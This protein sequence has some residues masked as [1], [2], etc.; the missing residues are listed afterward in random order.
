MFL[1][2]SVVVL[3]ACIILLLSSIVKAHR[4]LFQNFWKVFYLSRCLY[5]QGKQ[6]Q[7]C[8]DDD[9]DSHVCFFR[10]L[11]LFVCPHY[12]IVI[13]NC[14]CLS[15]VILELYQSN[16]IASYQHMLMHYPLH[17]NISLCITYQQTLMHCKYYISTY[18][19]TLCISIH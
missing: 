14:Q 5:N 3:Y 12:T 13:V 11:L 16:S 15:L 17:I 6:G 10:L 1:S 9:D 18:V 4:M 2:K 8:N 19:Y 7:L